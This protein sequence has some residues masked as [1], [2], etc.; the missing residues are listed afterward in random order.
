MG[1]D[2]CDG[3]CADGSVDALLVDELSWLW[4]Q[5]GAAADRR[6]D[7]SLVSG[8][9]DVRATDS[10]EERAV[11]SGLLGGRLAAGQ[12]RQVDLSQ[13]AKRTAPLTPGAVAA[14]A[15]GRPLAVR[16]AERARLNA[17]EAALRL[18]LSERIPG[19][20]TEPAWGA[21]KRSG[22]VARLVQE[23]GFGV[24]DQ[25]SSVIEALPGA[26]SA[27]VDRRRLAQDTTGNPHSLDAGQVLGSFTLA[28]LSATGRIDPNLQSRDAWAAVG[29]AYDDIT[30][31]LTMVGLTPSG[32]VVP[33]AMPVTVPP[34]VLGICG[35]EPGNGR[36]VFVTENPS[37]LGAAL[38]VADARVVCTSGTPSRVEVAALRRMSDRGWSLRV[39]AD[40]DAAGLRHVA[41]ILAGVPGAVHWRMGAVDYLAGL[42]RTDAEVPLRSGLLPETPWDCPLKETM[43]EQGTAVFEEC[44]L[45]ELLED[46]S[47]AG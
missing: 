41:A 29:V 31:G 21:L 8:R 15:L 22:W 46:V 14:H 32:W 10:V 44:F 30:G 12:R 4:A 11:A 25:A 18:R 40:F 7:A 19:A 2:I 26:D 17:A 16:A 3:S 27:S 36:T 28:V 33:G 47:S 6:G 23:N 39:R 35:W 9:L 1:C 42:A 34:V 43:V 24:V 45:D 37:V 13:L 38:E 20:A 5:V